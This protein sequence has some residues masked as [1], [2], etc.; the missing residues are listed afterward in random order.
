[1]NAS[2]TEAAVI[3]TDYAELWR[4]QYHFST[5]DSRI[6]DPNGLVYYEGV[7]HLYFQ[8]LPHCKQIGKHWGHATSDDLIHWTERENALFPDDLGHMWSGTAVVDEENTSG[9]FTDTPKKRGIVAAYSTNTQHIGIAYSKDGGM[10]FQKISTSEPVIKNPDI[11]AFRDPHIF[12]HPE[13]DM[14][15]MV[16]AG[17]GGMLWIY[18]SPDLLHWS[19]CSTDRSVNTECPNLFRMRVEGS[20]EEK[21]IL[22]CVGREYYVG[23]FDGV[24]FTDESGRLSLNEGP[25]A[26][27][28]ITFSNMPDGRTVMIS[29]MNA[30]HTAADGKW[31]GCFT[32]PVELKL[33]RYGDSYRIVQSPVREISSVT[34]QELISVRDCVTGNGENLLAGVESNCFDLTAEFQLHNHAPFSLT[35]CEGP[36][37][38]TVL[39]YNPVTGCLCVDRSRSLY[40]PAEMT[41]QTALY[42]FYIDPDTMPDGIL[43]IRL[44]VDIA[45]LELFVN[46]GHYYFVMRIHP[47]PDSRRMSLLCADQ[48]HIRSMRV[49]SCRSI[50]FGDA[51][52]NT[53]RIPDGAVPVEAGNPLLHEPDRL[54]P[55]WYSAHATVEKNGNIYM[56]KFGSGVVSVL[57]E[58]VRDFTFSSELSFHGEGIAD[59][60]FRMVNLSDYYRLRLDALTGKTAL[61]RK[62]GGETTEICSVPTAFRVN[63][64]YRLHVQMIGASIEVCMDGVC[65][66]RAS[67]TVFS[68]GQLG[69]NVHAADVSLRD[70]ASSTPVQLLSP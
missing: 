13:T 36:E 67:D 26:Y 49:C 39:T 61:F 53:A 19:L 25:D 43:R 3:P 66:L 55:F 12:R 40:G 15:K 2:I 22:S 62:C 63:T 24:R 17:K 30:F 16:V 50:W 29:W 1:M 42:S 5:L 56:H 52:V 10:T 28:G 59:I 58:N 60:L 23:S 48:L 18:E 34:A 20:T 35:V 6:N 8:S 65:I 45:N 51:A 31:N 54:A 21:W 68:E 47:S 57:A 41:R 38:G 9:L 4:P 33:I 69:L 14:W 70:I 11:R 27:A 7:Y 44:L 64:P 46:G 37:E 32:V